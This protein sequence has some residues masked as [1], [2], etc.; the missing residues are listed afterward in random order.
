MLRLLTSGFVLCEGFRMPAHHKWSQALPGRRPKTCKGRSRGLHFTS[1]KAAAVAE[2]EH[3]ASFETIGNHQQAL[4]FIRTYYQWNL[5]RCAQVIDLGR[6]V[7]TPQRHPEQEAQ[8][9]HDDVAGADTYAGLG[10][11]QLESPDVLERGRPGR[12]LQKRRKPL[13]AAD[14]ASLRART[15]LARIHV[16]DHTLTQRGDSL[17]CQG[18]SCLG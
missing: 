1:T 13:A 17:G 4:G 2:T 3:H 16:F 15:E 9:G 18:N 14:M 12:S 10:Q 7:Q 5:L 8:P 11:V 6:E